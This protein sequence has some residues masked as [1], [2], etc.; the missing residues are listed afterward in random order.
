MIIVVIIMIS[1]FTFTA[2]KYS[3]SG[4]D[5]KVWVDIII[6]NFFTAIITIEST[7]AVTIIAIASLIISNYPKMR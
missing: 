2:S 1:G 5:T 7:V 6:I 3:M 4:L